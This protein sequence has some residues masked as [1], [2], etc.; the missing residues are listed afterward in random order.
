[1]VT[2]IGAGCISGAC[3]PARNTAF[4]RR[5]RSRKFAGRARSGGYRGASHPLKLQGPRG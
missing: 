1:V 5:A 4:P 2:E 3:S